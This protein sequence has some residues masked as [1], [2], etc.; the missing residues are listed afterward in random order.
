MGWIPAVIAIVIE[1]IKLIIALRKKG[2]S[3]E[4]CSVAL[5]DARKS[6][7]MTRLE[8]ILDRLRQGKDCE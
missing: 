3:V 2:E 6:G 5:R 8:K 7:D 4:S 1:I